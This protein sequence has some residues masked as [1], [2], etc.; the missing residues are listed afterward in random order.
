MKFDQ[1]LY[2]KQI[3]AE[4]KR[5]AQSPRKSFFTSGFEVHADT[6][7]NQVKEK[8]FCTKSQLEYL[9][10]FN[11]IEGIERPHHLSKEQVEKTV[12]LDDALDKDKR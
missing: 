1:K 8:G 3:E 2:A 6:I 11:E 7:M 5:I 9:V 10:L 12:F 4:G